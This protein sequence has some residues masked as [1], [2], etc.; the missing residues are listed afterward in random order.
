MS[1]Q[2]QLANQRLDA[3]SKSA[4]DW[5]SVY[6]LFTLYSLSGQMYMYLCWKAVAVAV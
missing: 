4:C 2:Q 3:A 6:L 1:K 5:L